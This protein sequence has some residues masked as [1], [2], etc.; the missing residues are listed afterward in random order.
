M[1]IAVFIFTFTKHS[2]W[3]AKYAYA[4]PS[5]VLLGGTDENGEP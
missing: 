4:S 2:L 5:I 3:A 1:L